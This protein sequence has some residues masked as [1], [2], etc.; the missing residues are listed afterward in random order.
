VKTEAAILWG[1]NQPWSV[2]EVELDDPHAHEIRVRLAACG[3]CHS[4]D[5]CVK[6]DLMVGMPIIGGHEGAG[7]VEAVGPGVTRLKEGDHVVLA[8][9]P[10]CGYCRWCSSG[11][12]NLCDLG[13][14][15]MEG[16]P[17]DGTFR[18]HARG[19]GLRTMSLLGTFSPYVVCPEASA[20]KV[21]DDLPLDI[22]ALVGCGVTTGWGAAVNLAKV[23][24]GDT[25]VVVGAGGL[26][27]SA[28]QGARVSGAATI[29]A[30]DPVE[31]KRESAMR[32]GATHTA[33]SWT[34]AMALVADLTRGVMADAAVFTGSLVQAEDVGQLMS[35]V[36]KGGRA[37][38]T[39]TANPSVQQV[40]LSLVEFVFFQKELK[41]NVFGGGNP[42]VE[43]PKLLNLY[44]QGVLKL[45]EMVTKEYKL[46]DINEGY[47]DLL[48]GKNVRGLI[49]Y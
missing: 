49:R 15:L 12:Q 20:I 43:I 31:F 30:V 28:I 19:E 10:A 3:L 6:G 40:S 18:A 4:D 21:D 48:D 2:E 46:T 26:G 41:G 35:L 29:V 24:P 27:T 36:R 5:H 38:I 42:F 47:A 17:L 23:E 34:E 7:V 16:K 9:I 22:A 37:V 39:S 32:F 44:R 25:V 8:F 14:A 45:D 13:A 11:H 1:V 33:A